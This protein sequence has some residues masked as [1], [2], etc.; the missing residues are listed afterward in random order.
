MF[1]KKEKSH[2]K[3]IIVPS[4]LLVLIVISAQIILQYEKVSNDTK[5][6]A[7]IKKQSSLEDRINQYREKV[8]SVN[9]KNPP[10]FDKNARE[11]LKIQL[12]GGL[13]NLSHA[14]N[15]N[16]KSSKAKI[17]IKQLPILSRV[18][19]SCGV[20]SSLA[21][22]LLEKAR[23]KPISGNLRNIITLYDEKDLNLNF[24]NQIQKCIELRPYMAKFEVLNAKEHIGAS[25]FG[26]KKSDFSRIVKQVKN[27]VIAN[28]SALKNEIEKLNINASRQIDY[29]SLSLSKIPNWWTIQLLN[30]GQVFASFVVYQKSNKKPE[31]IQSQ[32][33]WIPEFKDQNF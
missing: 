17:D 25:V 19:S 12:N 6:Y 21:K 3:A 20:P 29:N 13:Y 9:P 10:V 24:L 33:L 11:T 26:I 7:A 1:L 32:I 31:I 23:Q 30:D 22:A 5:L 4:M 16:K 14:L 8:L 28:K 27:G 18:L 15:W 2:L